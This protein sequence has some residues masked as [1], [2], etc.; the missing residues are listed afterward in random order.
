M[1]ETCGGLWVG[2]IVREVKSDETEVGLGEGE[3]LELGP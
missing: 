1:T 2:N 3:V